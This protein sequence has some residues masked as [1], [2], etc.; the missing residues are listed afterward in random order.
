MPHAHV[1]LILDK[2]NTIVTPDQINQYVC[3]RIPALPKRDDYSPEANQKRREWYG[4]TKF[5]LHDCNNSCERLNYNG[6]AINN[7]V[8][9]FPKEYSSETIISGF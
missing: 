7:C 3:A 9:H 6:P 8:K 5:M 4:V 1:L 2:N